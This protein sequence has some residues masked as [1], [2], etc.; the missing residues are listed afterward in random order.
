VEDVDAHRNIRSTAAALRRTEEDKVVN[1]PY[2][3][4][5]ICLMPGGD[6]PTR[7]GFFDALLSGCVPVVFEE[8]S[9]IH[10]WWFHWGAD[11]AVDA[12]R[13]ALSAV[14]FIPR[15]EFLLNVSQSMYDLALLSFNESFM[16]SKLKTMKKIA[17]R[18]QYS[19]PPTGKSFWMFNHDAYFRN[20]RSLFP[21]GNDENECGSLQRSGRVEHVISVESEKMFSTSISE[22]GSEDSHQKR[23][24][25][26]LFSRSDEAL[27]T[28]A[29]I[30]TEEERLLDAFDI[31]LLQ[32]LQD[33]R[34]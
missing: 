33:V 32:L 19:L 16:L 1:N 6:F 15:D 2:I 17:H 25:S 27:N 4:S 21:A 24:E 26:V 22:G 12:A 14:I 3:L 13:I 8:S 30:N 9:S 34:K 23:L 28:D 11:N 31:A 20:T 5:R 7:K 18:M 10:Q 29:T